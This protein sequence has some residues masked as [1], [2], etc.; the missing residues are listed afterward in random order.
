MPPDTLKHTLF[1]YL[2]IEKRDLFIYHAFEKSDLFIYLIVQHTYIDKYKAYVIRQFFLI[3]FSG[4][5]RQCP[6]G[7]KTSISAIV[8]YGKSVLI[9]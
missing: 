1:I 6:V 2:V 8:A 3:L 7:G 5:E 4:I 9:I